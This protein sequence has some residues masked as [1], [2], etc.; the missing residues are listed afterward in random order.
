MCQNL[1]INPDA[2]KRKKIK[3][4]ESWLGPFDL[5]PS[6]QKAAPCQAEDVDGSQ[7]V[8]VTDSVTS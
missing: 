3:K 5:L 6:D 1:H 8:D 4:R 7:E 2:S